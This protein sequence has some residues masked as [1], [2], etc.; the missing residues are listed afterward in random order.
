M[1]T[2]DE[3]LKS[4]GLLGSFQQIKKKTTAERQSLL[5]KAGITGAVGSKEATQQIIGKT[6]PSLTPITKE[7]G[8]GVPKIG[9]GGFDTGLGVGALPGA[10]TPKDDL[11]KKL[12]DALTKAQGGAT[13]EESLAT[14][15]E[16]RGVPELKETVGTF[17]EEIGKAQDLLSD[18]DIQIRRGLSREEGRL[19]AT[20]VIRGKQAQLVEIESIKRGDVLST[21][22]T[23]QRGK[24]RAESTL[25][26][27]EKDILTIL[28]LREAEKG[29]PLE[30]LKDEIAVRKSIR[31]LTKVDIPD[32]VSSTFNDAGDLTIVTQDPESGDFTTKVLPGIGQK[33][34]YD[35]YYTQKNEAG[36]LTFFGIKDGKV[37]QLGKFEGVADA[38][39]P[40]LDWANDLINLNPDASYE[41][42]YAQ[43]DESTGMSAKAIDMAL[44]AA[45]KESQKAAEARGGELTEDY[46]RSVY[47]TE[48]LEEA[49]EAAG[50]GDRGI[51]AFNLRDL[52]VQGYID[53]LV[54]N[55]VIKNG[56]FILKGQ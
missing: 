23:L 49:A 3:R 29:K 31:D 56:K 54:K 53:N 55:Y 5:T 8:A 12:T 48:K 32:V 10:T 47:T 24:E 6:L 41:E 19:A 28:G 21:I 27:E 1:P 14:L 37:E 34:G 46:I 40:G 51:G 15:R 9:E 30:A 25:E 26:R 38:G 17:D 4:M 16:E 18:L 20:D 22:D 35:Q 45:G 50:F 52:D 43:I 11:V 39:E 13:P 7:A 33:K 42:L 44:I 36:D 2:L